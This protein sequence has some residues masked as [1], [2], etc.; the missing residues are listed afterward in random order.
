M[1]KHIEGLDVQI[2]F[3]A[4]SDVLGRFLDA[5]EQLSDDDFVVRLTADDPFKC[6]QVIDDCV[7]VALDGGFDYVSNNIEG[8]GFPEGLDVEVIRVRAR[9]LAGEEA[10]SQS[11]REHV[12]PYIWRDDSKIFQ[13]ASV[14]AIIDKGHWSLTVDYQEDLNRLSDIYNLLALTI[15]STY[16]DILYLSKHIQVDDTLFCSER[17][18]NEG[19]VKSIEQD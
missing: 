4:E 13:K 10:I 1:V 9:R 12:T 7:L 14:R 5:S 18:R 19:Y 11:D 2:S 6:P 17:V 15:E 3:G 16:R 8:M